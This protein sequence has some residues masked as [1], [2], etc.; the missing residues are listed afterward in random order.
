MPA[1]RQALLAGG[2][3]IEAPLIGLRSESEI[4]ARVQALKEDA[5]AAPISARQVDLIEALLEVRATMVHAVSH[6]RD[7]VV[8]M[9]HIATAVARVAS[10]EVALAA[11]GVIC[12]P[13][14]RADAMMR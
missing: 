9:P 1:T 12:P 11:R 10:R 8:D 7:L 4:A 3:G 13:W 14:L 5:A 2:V 6:L